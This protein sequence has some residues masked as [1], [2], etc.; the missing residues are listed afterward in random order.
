MRFRYTDEMTL[1]DGAKL[2]SITY[3]DLTVGYN[4]SFANEALTIT[5]GINNLF[6]QDPPVCFPC[7]VI[8]MSITSHGLPGRY[9]YLRLTY[10]N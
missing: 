8:G 2:D 1:D 3:T 6:D 10:Q 7:G 5:L 4:P 9:G